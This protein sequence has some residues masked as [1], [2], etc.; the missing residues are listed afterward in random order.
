[1]TRCGKEI[2]SHVPS[3]QSVLNRDT[4]ALG[5]NL[6]GGGERGQSWRQVWTEEP[7]GQSD[8]L[9]QATVL[10]KSDPGNVGGVP[11]WAP[12]QQEPMR[13][14]LP[15]ELQIRNQKTGLDLGL[16]F[17]HRSCFLHPKPG[18]DFLLDLPHFN[19]QRSPP[20]PP[21]PCPPAPPMSW[22]RQAA[23]F[24]SSW[25]TSGGWGRQASG[26]GHTAPFVTVA[27][28]HG[29]CHPRGPWG[30]CDGRWRYCGAVVAPTPVARNLSHGNER[31]GR[32][33]GALVEKQVVWVRMLTLLMTWL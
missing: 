2:P 1:M 11:A 27:E 21:P 20:T 3:A 14:R 15:L 16:A 25:G 17:H 10:L 29:Q 5:L 18:L 22:I 13:L 23:C 19:G 33:L 9:S 26:T 8:L 7:S 6:Q 28:S 24:F 12:P 4:R 32:W 30:G 31:T